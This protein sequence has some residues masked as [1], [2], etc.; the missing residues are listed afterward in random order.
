MLKSNSNKIMLCGVG[1]NYNKFFK[2]LYN[3]L[4]ELINI[5]HVK[6]LEI[7]TLNVKLIDDRRK[8][9]IDSLDLT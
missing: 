8:K 9:N 3:F 2:S 1:N 4:S 7:L 5:F 6:G